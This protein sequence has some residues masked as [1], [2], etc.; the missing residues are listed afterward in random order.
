MAGN[1]RLRPVSLADLP[2]LAA[3]EREAFSD[4]WTVAQLRTAMAWTGAIALIADDG[5]GVVGYVLGRVIVDEGEILSLATIARRRRQGFGRRLLGA[6]LEAMRERGAHAVWLEVR[7]S[8]A[9]ARAMYQSAGFAT[10]GIRP[11]YY[12]RPDEDALVLRCE[13]AAT[14]SRGSAVR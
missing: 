6:M 14:A 1:C 9:A 11:G 13:L 8:N 4:P 2:G 7:M 10:A 3:L 5:V 12:N